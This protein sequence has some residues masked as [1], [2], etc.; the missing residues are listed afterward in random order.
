[1]KQLVDGFLRYL[2][3]E[4]GSSGNTITAY[5]NDLYAFLKFLEYEGKSSEIGALTEKDI[6][7]FLLELQNKGYSN[8]TRARKTAS[9]KSFYGFLHSEGVIRE[10]VM[11]HLA[12]PKIGRSLPIPLSEDEID[13]LLELPAASNGLESPRDKAMLEVLYATG[14]RVSELV[15]LDLADCDL[16]DNYVRCFGKNSRERMVPFHSAAA[17]ALSIYINNGRQTFPNITL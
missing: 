17:Q 5:R 15:G 1:M 4:K 13:L 11:I 12:G 16:I 10:N 9:L 6:S 2:A 7:G 3:V 8:T 14:M